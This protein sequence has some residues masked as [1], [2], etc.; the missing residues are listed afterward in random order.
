M[1]F[2]LLGPLQTSPEVKL[3]LSGV[4]NTPEASTLALHAL[5][6]EK[7]HKTLNDIF[8]IL[9][10]FTF[11]TSS[12]HFFR[13][14]C[15]Y[16]AMRW[17]RMLAVHLAHAPENIPYVLPPDVAFPRSG[18]SILVIC[19]NGAFHNASL[20]KQLMAAAHQ[21]VILLRLEGWI[22]GHNSLTI[23]LAPLWHHGKGLPIF[24]FWRNAQK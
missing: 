13:G 7:G 4:K 23:V 15:V 19:T 10:I 12:G 6:N 8:A 21:E 1:Y 20:L 3:I 22:N 11:S 17:L 16:H 5:R 18:V 24:L 14:Q 9:W 2:G